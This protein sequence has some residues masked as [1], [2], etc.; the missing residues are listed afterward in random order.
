M[1]L[2]KVI[3]GVAIAGSSL[4]GGVIGATLLNGTATAQTSTTQS[5]P[6]P[7]APA[8]KAPRDP[9]MGGH[10]GA[11]GIAEALLTGDAAEKVKAAAL[12][13]V[14]GG[15]IERVEN[16]AEGAT[17]EA[18]MVDATGKHVTVKLDSNFAVTG[19]ESGR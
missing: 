9:S 17:Y 8:A 18:H 16:D 13:A 12:A 2:R 6:A 15:T 4:T 5:T 14:Q 10:V 19:M 7:P 11:N 1:N 3:V